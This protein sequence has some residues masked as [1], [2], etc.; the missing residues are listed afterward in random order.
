MATPASLALYALAWGSSASARSFGSAT[1]ATGDLCFVAS[2]CDDFG[3]FPLTVAKAS[4]TATIST[5]TA[6][7]TL[8]VSGNPGTTLH[9]FSVTAGGTLVISVQ[10]A[11]STRF[12]NSSL[13][14]ATGSA[15]FTSATQ[16][17]SSTLT[18]SFTASAA[19]A[20]FITLNDVTARA[21]NTTAWT[22]TS[23]VVE[24]YALTDG[25][26]HNASTGT[27]D[28]DFQAHWLNVAGGAVT[29]GLTAPTSTSIQIV[30]WEILGGVATLAPKSITK[31]QAVNRSYTY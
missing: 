19:S 31:Q 6:S 14:V 27:Q 28:A 13:I 2:N 30:V 20:V 17:L 12:F 8:T 1:V 15:G 26:S 23:G 18:K 21:T 4:G 24:D 11:L 10:A 7:V 3:G 25:T 9:T 22:P 16:A 29:Y 5:V